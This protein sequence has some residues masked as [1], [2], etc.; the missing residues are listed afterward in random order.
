MKKKFLFVLTSV[1]SAIVLLTGCGNSDF[2]LTQEVLCGDVILNIPSNYIAQEED[3]PIDSA[4]NFW[5]FTPEDFTFEDDSDAFIRVYSNVISETTGK[6]ERV[7][8]FDSLLEMGYEPQLI[9]ESTEERNGGVFYIYSAN[10]TEI[11]Y[12]RTVYS[13]ILCISKG[14]THVHIVIV[15]YFEATVN[16]LFDKIYK[17]IEVK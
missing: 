5:E 15:G 9:E 1:L 10:Y 17:T 8:Y 3:V 12:E 6:F 4:E 2:D 11:T 13:K 16:S 7:E 14:D